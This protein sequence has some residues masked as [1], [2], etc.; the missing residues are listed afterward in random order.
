ME[1][2]TVESDKVFNECVQR[3]GRDHG[4]QSS[5]LEKRVV[6]DE[7]GEGKEAESG[8]VWGNETFCR[9]PAAKDGDLQ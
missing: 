1:N 5:D 8:Q 2:R 9:G 6:M 3:D 7:V 4:S